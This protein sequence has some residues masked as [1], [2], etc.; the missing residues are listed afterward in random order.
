MRG[1][2]SRKDNFLENDEKSL[3][4]S[5]TKVFKDIFFLFPSGSDGKEFFLLLIYCCAGSLLMKS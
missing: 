5:Q 2:I 4:E 1:E 3:K